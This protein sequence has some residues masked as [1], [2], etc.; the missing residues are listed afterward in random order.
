MQYYQGVPTAPAP[1][2]INV[3]AAA[4]AAP[5]PAP[6]PAPQY[7]QVVA[8]APAAASALAVA[9]VP[10]A[11]Q[12]VQLVEEYNIDNQS[13]WCKEKSDGAFTER[14]YADIMANCQPGHWER[15]QLLPFWV[16]E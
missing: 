11:P 13:F 6:V 2:H 10:A 5:A 3:V 15:G 4:A 7:I 9:A 8:P 1:Q 16:E 14:T 12:Q